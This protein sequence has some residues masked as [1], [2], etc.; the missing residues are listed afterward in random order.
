MTP[1]CSPFPVPNTSGVFSKQ[2][3]QAFSFSKHATIYVLQ[4][5]E[6]EWIAA[7]DV[8]TPENSYYVPLITTSER[9]K[10]LND[11][12]CSMAKRVY[13]YYFTAPAWPPPRWAT[14]IHLNSLQKMKKAFDDFFALQ[15][16]E[17]S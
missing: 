15:R 10:T 1:A 6:D 17:H 2:E 13:G 14:K 7:F 4:V 16:G 11:A 12:L 9:F 3:A 8:E 5:A